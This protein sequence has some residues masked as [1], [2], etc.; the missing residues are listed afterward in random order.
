M[1]PGNNHLLEKR[2]N[3]YI[4]WQNAVDIIAYATFLFSNNT[5]IEY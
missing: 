3:T 5:I 2:L 4:S 1:K